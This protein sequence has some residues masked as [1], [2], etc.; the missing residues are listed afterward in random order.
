MSHSQFHSMNKFILTHAWLKLR[1]KHM[2]TGRINQVAFLGD[3]TTR[4][5]PDADETSI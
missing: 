2:T 3:T 5:I 1:D 4:T